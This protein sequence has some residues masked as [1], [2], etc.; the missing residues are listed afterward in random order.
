MRVALSQPCQPAWTKHIVRLSVPQHKSLII[1]DVCGEKNYMH[2]KGCMPERAVCMEASLLMK[3][4]LIINDDAGTEQERNA[5]QE[6]KT[7][8]SKKTTLQTDKER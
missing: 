3:S 2:V 6:R 5:Y 4:M 7:W 1:H 8:Q